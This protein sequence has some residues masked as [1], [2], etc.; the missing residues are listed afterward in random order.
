[1]VRII[2]LTCPACGT[3]VAGNVLE[4]HRELQCPGID[5]ETVLRFGDLTPDEQDHL[6]SNASAYSLED[7]E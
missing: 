2:T 5:C 4:S 3:I 6:K 7:D 1:M